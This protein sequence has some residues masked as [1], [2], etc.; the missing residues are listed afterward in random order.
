M[1]L[2]NGFGIVAQILLTSNQDD[3]KA[4][5]EVENLGNPLEKRKH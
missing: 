2:L 4:L 3:G 1:Q 5:A